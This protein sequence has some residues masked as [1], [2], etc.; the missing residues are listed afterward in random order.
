[1]ILLVSAVSQLVS[2]AITPPPSVHLNSIIDLVSNKTDTLTK[3]RAP[4]KNATYM[5][6][7]SLKLV[8]K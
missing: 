5:Q 7:L 3:V 1:M 2:P 6:C 4:L 8:I